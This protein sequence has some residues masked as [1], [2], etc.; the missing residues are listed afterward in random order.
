PH[1]KKRNAMKTM[2]F[3]QYG[4]PEVLQPAEAPEVHPGP[5]QVRVRVRAAGINPVDWKIRSGVSRRAIPVALPHVPGM[6][7]AGVVDELGPD[8]TGVDLG[9]EVFGATTT[10]G[11][12]EHAVL[13]DWAGKPAEM[14]WAVAG[15]LAMAVETAARGLDVLGELQGKTLLVSGAAGGVGTAAVQLAKDRGAW[16]IGTASEDNL[17]YLT[18]LGAEPCVYG[19]GLVDRVRALAPHGVD[20][21]LDVAGHGV[22]PD[23]LTLTGSPDR[24]VTL[25]DP[26]AARFGMV[27]TTGSEGRAYYALAEAAE[28]FR[29]GSFV[30][31]VAGTYPLVELAEAHRVSETGHVRGKLVLELD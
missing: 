17:D 22:L 3:D 11:A 2:Q 1:E 5:G 6:E 26:D 30:M 15:G 31:P 29:Q 8:V 25:I 20:L 13:S 24:V 18:S 28:L 12:T 16:V 9:D 4:P 19:P 7:A 14:S 27:F 23:L 10:G 21:A